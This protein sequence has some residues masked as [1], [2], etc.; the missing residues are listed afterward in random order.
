[1]KKQQ[2]K[3]LRFEYKYWVTDAA[4][5]QLLHLAD[6]Y[7]ICDDWAPGGQRNT[8]LYL[9]SQELDMV[10]LH[11]ESAPDRFK[12]RIRVYGDPPKDPAFI[13]IKRKLKSV[14]CKRR[15]TVPL[16]AVPALLSDCSDPTWQFQSAEER[17]TFEQFLYLKL[18]YKAEPKVL[19]T[20]CREAYSS[21]DPD[22]GIRLTLDRQVCYQPAVGYCLQGDPRAWTPLCGLGN[23]QPGASTLIEVKFPGAAPLWLAETVQ[24]LHLIRCSYSKYIS[25]MIFEE[26]GPDGL[27]GLNREQRPAAFLSRSS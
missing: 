23:Y 22:E 19:V 5:E 10:Q 2:T 7:I 26:L 25:A 18:T 11:T 9:D 24:R 27:L 12:L 15:V 3:F 13:E 8:S 6:P 14:C 17:E 1:M 16:A 4:A 21:R 20:C